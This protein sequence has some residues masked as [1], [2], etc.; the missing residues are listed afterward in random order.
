MDLRVTLELMLAVASLF[1]GLSW[2]SLRVY[3]SYQLKVVEGSVLSNAEGIKYL[4][5]ELRNVVYV[6]KENQEDLEQVLREITELKVKEAQMTHA[7]SKQ[8]RHF[9]AVIEPIKEIE[10]IKDMLEELNTQLGS[11][12]EAKVEEKVEEM[13]EEM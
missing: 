6:V 5:R 10:P 1:F 13:L 12:L 4:D 8:M 2:F 11:L 7:M 3:I 9:V